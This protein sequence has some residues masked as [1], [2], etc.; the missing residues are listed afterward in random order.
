M[1]EIFLFLSSIKKDPG[2]NRGTPAPISVPL[3]WVLK[4][5]YSNICGEASKVHLADKDAIADRNVVPGARLQLC[6]LLSLSLSHTDTQTVFL[7]TTSTLSLSLRHLSP[8]S[9][10]FSTVFSPS[11]HLPLPPS[12]RSSPL[13]LSVLYFRLHISIPISPSP[14]PTHNSLLPPSS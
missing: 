7:S 4:V 14:T 6:I 13:L 10:T 8:L 5:I 1:P 9:T 2:P 11:S 12:P 3:I